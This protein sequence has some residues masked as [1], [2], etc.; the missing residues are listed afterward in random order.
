MHPA[1]AP[2]SESAQVYTRT[3]FF[4]NEKQENF[5]RR[6]A[7]VGQ[8]DAVRDA[9]IASQK[10]QWPKAVIA[11]GDLL[12]VAELSGRH[13]GEPSSIPVGRS[14]SPQSQWIARALQTERLVAPGFT[15]ALA[16]HRQAASP[17]AADRDA[18]ETGFAA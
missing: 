6:A 18:R 9:N 2:V 13:G 10:G 15:V 17:P 5:T 16:A 14:T 11:R 1:P 12:F 7:E 4:E 8:P 3:S